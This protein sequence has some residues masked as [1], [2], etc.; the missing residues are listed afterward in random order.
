VPPLPHPT[1]ATT[2]PIS[3]PQNQALKPPHAREMMEQPTGAATAQV[4]SKRGKGADGRIHQ[5]MVEWGLAL[6]AV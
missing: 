5:G 2:H 4:R 3:H 1:E 6:G